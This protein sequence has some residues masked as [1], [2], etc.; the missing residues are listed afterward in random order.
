M[1]GAWPP[2]RPSGRTPLAS[3]RHRLHEAAA[4]ARARARDVRG[5]WGDRRVLP[6][7]R[8]KSAY[9]RDFEWQVAWPGVHATRSAVSS[10]MRVDRKSVGPIRKRVADDLRAERGAGLFDGLRSI[11]VDETSHRKGHTY[12]TVV[13]DR[14][15]GASSGCTTGTGR[16]SSTCSSG[17]SRP[18]GAPPSG[19]SSTATGAR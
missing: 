19:W 14:D 10:L 16:R 5:A 15:R 2:V 13:I 8:R 17:R 6:R 11:G 4:G 9:T 12:M 3:P 7:V 1:R 18:D